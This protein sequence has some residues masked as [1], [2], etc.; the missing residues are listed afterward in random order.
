MKQY[1]W[2][3]NKYNDNIYVL[4]VIVV[5]L[6]LFMINFDFFQRKQDIEPGFTPYNILDSITKE[7]FNN[8]NTNTNTQSITS[9]QPPIVTNPYNDLFISHREKTQFELARSLLDGNDESLP[10]TNGSPNNYA[11]AHVNDILQQHSD[12]YSS[13]TN[14]QNSEYTIGNYATLDSMGKS[15]TDTL[16]GIHTNLGYT[17][18]DEQ[19]GTFTRREMNNPYTYDNISNYNMGIN[20]ASV[21]GISGS[22]TGISGRYG[23]NERPIFLQK[24]FEGVA[25]IFAPNIVIQNSPLTTDG[26]PDISFHM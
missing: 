6:L 22:G 25:N 16:G 23:S 21:N 15:L 1:T 8:T 11:K 24:D 5:L 20:P 14:L 7:L 3:Y 18:L 2:I 10:N 13:N 19:L 12:L 9:Y 4:F 26:Y 17:I